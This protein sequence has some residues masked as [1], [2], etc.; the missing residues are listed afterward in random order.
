MDQFLNILKI[1]DV[2]DSDIL[3]A[4]NSKINDMRLEAANYITSLYKFDITE[5]NVNENSIIKDINLFRKL[6]VQLCA[7]T[8]DSLQSVR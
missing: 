4:L 2:I 6:L 1:Q 8:N 3:P 5:N 7:L